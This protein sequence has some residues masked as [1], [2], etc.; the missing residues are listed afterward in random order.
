ME[1]ASTRNLPSRVPF[2]TDKSLSE[3]IKVVSPT[4]ITKPIRTVADYLVCRPKNR[5][6]TDMRE[7][8]VVHG[9]TPESGKMNGQTVWWQHNPF[10][11][12]LQIIT[13]VAE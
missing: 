6:D 3:Y 10:S 2:I 13:A 8:I 5:R 1:I 4:G 12:L 9:S 7:P 11:G